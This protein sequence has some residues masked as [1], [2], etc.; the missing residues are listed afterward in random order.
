MPNVAVPDRESDQQI[1]GDISIGAADA[2]VGGGIELAGI[3][4]T[5][6]AKDDNTKKLIAAGSGLLG[7][8]RKIILRKIKNFLNCNL[9]FKQN[10]C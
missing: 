1:A 4:G 2:L 8:G 9:R 6:L 7:A 10:G 3:I 5:S